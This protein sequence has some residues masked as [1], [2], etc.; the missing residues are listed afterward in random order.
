[1]DGTKHWFTYIQTQRGLSLE[2]IRQAHLRYTDGWIQIP[3]FSLDGEYL[4]S[5]Y[6]VA[7][8]N[9]DQSIKYRYDRGSMTTLYN[10]QH[11]KDH[12]TIYITE[13]EFDCLTLHELG[14]TAVSSTGGCMSFKSAWAPLFE[15]K[16]V[17]IVFDNDDAGLT[18]AAYTISQLTH[19]TVSVVYLPPQYG[20]DIN[21]IYVKHGS[22]TLYELL[23]QPMLTIDVPPMTTKKAR[24]EW[25]GYIGTLA[26]E[27]PE[28]DNRAQLLRRIVKN[29]KKTEKSYQTTTHY[30]PLDD[31][32]KERAKS[33]PI[34]QL[35]KV[36]RQRRFLCPFHNDSEP[37]M[38]LY[39]NNTAYCFVCNHYADAIDIYGAVH[40]I[41]S[42]QPAGFKQILNELAP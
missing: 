6:R 18:G 15:G 12:Q 9:K 14:L 37:S 2:T 23:D 39:P 17:V 26:S 19:T 29:F 31:S 34:H 4:F 30:Q 1:M 27:Y 41:D 28:I 33:Y 22:G 36:N 40:D 10:Q 20:K 8:W 35:V 7:P 24:K 21:E 13:G 16:Q 3:V 32:Q 11:L 42:R 5:K 38:Y 25:L